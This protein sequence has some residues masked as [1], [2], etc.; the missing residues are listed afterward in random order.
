MPSLISRPTLLSIA[1]GFAGGFLSQAL[2]SPQSALA[3][4]VVPP[5]LRPQ[6]RPPATEVD[7][8][9]FALVDSAGNVNAEIKLADSEPEI[10]LYDKEGRPAW[11]ATTHQRGYQL[12]NQKSQ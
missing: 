2:F 4:L 9:R 8:Q 1:A 7:A 11:R 3:Q 12:L 6:K 10:I 5:Q